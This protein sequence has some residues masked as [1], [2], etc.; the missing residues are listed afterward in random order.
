[1]KYEVVNINLTKLQD[2]LIDA[3]I[4]FK[5]YLETKTLNETGVAKFAW[6]EFEDET[7]MNLV[8][9]IIE[10]HDPTPLLQKKEIEILKDQLFTIQ[11]ALYFIIMN[12]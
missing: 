1:M 2:Q 10:S 8:Q 11:G 6:C 4:R 12:Y 7:N 5:K 9:Q 3:G